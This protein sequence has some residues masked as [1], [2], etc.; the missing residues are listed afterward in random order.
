[1]QCALYE[2]NQNC[3]SIISILLL[4]LD[5]YAMLLYRMDLITLFV[6]SAIGKIGDLITSKNAEKKLLVINE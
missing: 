2:N 6:A 5:M 1:M 3:K 4:Q